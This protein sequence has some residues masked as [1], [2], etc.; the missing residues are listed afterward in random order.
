MNIEKRI[1]IFFASLSSILTFILFTTTLY[2]LF[3]GE[4][5]KSAVFSILVLISIATKAFERIADR[6]ETMRA[7]YL[8][9]VLEPHELPNSVEPIVFGREAR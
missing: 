5:A 1:D 8:V 9:G 2:Y 3:T 4:W 6:L 7:V